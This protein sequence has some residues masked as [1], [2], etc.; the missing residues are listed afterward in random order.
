MTSP[1]EARLAA[2]PLQRSLSAGPRLQTQTDD[3]L[4]SEFRVLQK[5]AS[6]SINDVELQEIAVVALLQSPGASSL[7]TPQSSHFSCGSSPWSC[8][9]RSSTPTS[10]L[11]PPT[12][13]KKH[14]TPPFNVYDGQ[15]HN[16]K[17]PLFGIKAS[18]SPRLA[19][20]TGKPTAPDRTN[21]GSP[22]RSADMTEN[23][24]PCHSNLTT[25]VANLTVDINAAAGCDAT[26]CQ[27][28][29]GQH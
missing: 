17:N 16:F 10:I 18:P 9:T 27:A 5:Y 7:S 21:L 24:T 19:A 26:P 4:Q 12:I 23:Q 29:Q 20:Y 2:I 28:A 22:A 25:A 8:T 1:V 15:P 14:R 6:L 13:E 11:N 3:S